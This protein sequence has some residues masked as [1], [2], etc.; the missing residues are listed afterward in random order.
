MSPQVT[1][2]GT[3]FPPGTGGKPTQEKTRSGEVLNIVPKVLFST[4]SGHPKPPR[5]GRN[6]REQ[7]GLLPKN[8]RQLPSKTL[9]INQT[10]NQANKTR[11]CQQKKNFFICRK[12]FSQVITK[13]KKF[14]QQQ[15]CI[16]STPR[17]PGKIVPNTPNFQENLLRNH[18]L[19]DGKDKSPPGRRGSNTPTFQESWG[20]ISTLHK[21]KKSL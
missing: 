12:N 18:F 5:L 15:T 21:Q 19:A 13:R 2:E 4:P 1:P 6:S 7:P 20:Q 16:F 14:L 8:S 11:V 10:L 3:D 17:D 9:Q